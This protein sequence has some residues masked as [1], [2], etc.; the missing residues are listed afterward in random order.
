MQISQTN[1]VRKAVILGREV[2]LFMW[3]VNMLSEL[4]IDSSQFQKSL[5]NE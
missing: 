2:R 3:R 5:K 1:I 4:H